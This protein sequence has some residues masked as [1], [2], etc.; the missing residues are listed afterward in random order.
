MRAFDIGTQYLQAA[1]EQAVN[2]TCPAVRPNGEKLRREGFPK[3]HDTNVDS[4][5]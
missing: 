5:E 2:V 1:A 3:R 4:D